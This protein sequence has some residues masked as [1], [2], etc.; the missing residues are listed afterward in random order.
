MLG[1]ES[2]HGVQRVF[3]DFF[4]TGEQNNWNFGPQSPEFDRNLMA[5]HFGHVVVDDYGRKST[6]QRDS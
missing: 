4:V 2:I 5:R 6:F 3:R 1:D